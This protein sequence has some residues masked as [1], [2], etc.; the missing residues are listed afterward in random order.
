MFACAV[1]PAWSSCMPLKKNLNV[2]PASG[3]LGILTDQALH[4][5][6]RG[7]FSVKTRTMSAAA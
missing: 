4:G 7:E 2:K 6:K 5:P 3:T 1:L